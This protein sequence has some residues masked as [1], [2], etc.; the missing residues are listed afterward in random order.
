MT[1]K[2]PGIAAS[3]IM[4]IRFVE[5]PNFWGL[6]GFAASSTFAAIFQCRN[7]ENSITFYVMYL[8]GWGGLGRLNQR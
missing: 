6:Q 5:N 1:K 3:P 8:R 4:A 2:L 7:E